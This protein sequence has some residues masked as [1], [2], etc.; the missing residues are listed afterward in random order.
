MTSSRILPGFFFER[1]LQVALAFPNRQPTNSPPPGKGLKQ[2]ARV[3][4]EVHITGVLLLPLDV[5]RLWFVSQ[6]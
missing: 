4:E 5:Q 6:T 2:G 1:I 3:R